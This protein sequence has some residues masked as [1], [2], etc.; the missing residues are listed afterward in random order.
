MK[1]NLV[2]L[3]LLPFLI[4][5]CRAENPIIING[6]DYKKAIIGKWKAINV[7]Q[8]MK[9]FQIDLPC[10]WE[11]KKNSDYYYL[12]TKYGIKNKTHG[13]Y[14]LNLNIR[15]VEIEFSQKK[16]KKAKLEGIIRFVNQ[17]TIEIV[18]YYRNTISR[19]FRF[20]EGEY[21]L[22]KRVNG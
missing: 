21:Q 15:P 12:F 17:N 18:F 16:P 22:Y 4:L 5:S 9:Q 3:L 6:I 10:K 1:K 7:G 14:E 2:L 13:S 8:I 19:V 20:R 11:F